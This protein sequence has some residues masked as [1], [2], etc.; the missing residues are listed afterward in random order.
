MSTRHL[1]VMAK[2]PRLGRVKTRLAADIGAVA[3]AGFYRRTLTGVTARLAGD[4][5]WRTWLGVSPDA[6]IADDA[7]WPAGPDRIAQGTGDLG[8]RMARLLAAP[9][10]GP[11]VLVGADI[12]AIRPDHVWQAFRALG[13]N[14]A[15]FGPAADGGFWLVGLKRLR[16]ADGIFAGVRWSSP[17]AL[18][19]TLANLPKSWRIARAATL[20][21]VDDGTAFSELG[22]AAK[23]R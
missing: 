2:S 22:R 13:R 17:Q 15:V 1:I 6:D 10:P 16:P 3:A 18:E 8:V 19:D 21:D 7:L 9:P 14:D 23:T 11:V 5:R 4:G 12:P 20:S